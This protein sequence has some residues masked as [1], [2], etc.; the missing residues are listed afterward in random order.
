MYRAS[1]RNH[2]LCLA[3]AL[4][5]VSGFATASPRAGKSNGR[6]HA[7]AQSGQ[8]VGRTVARTIAASPRELTRDPTAAA[9]LRASTVKPGKPAIVTADEAMKLVRPGSWVL[10]PAEA[11]VPQPLVD[12]LGRR[13]IAL[14]TPKSGKPVNVIHSASLAQYNPDAI[15]SGALKIT[16]PFINSGARPY[17][18]Q[19]GV[20]NMM[21]IDLSDIPVYLREKQRPNVVLVNTSLPDKRGYVYTGLGLDIIA[22]WLADPRV[23]VIALAN[24]NVPATGGTRLHQSHIDRMVMDDKPLS[25]LKWEPPTLVDRAIGRNVAE[26]VKNGAT[27][28][29]GIGPL[30]TA[31]GGAL[32]KRGQKINEGGGKFKVR[33]RTEMIDDGLL[34]MLKAGIVSGSRDAVQ[35][36]FVAGTQPLYQAL[37]HDKRIKILP[38][39]VLNDPREAAKRNNLYAINSGVTLDLYGQSCAEMVPRTSAD[40]TMYPEA[41]SG[42]GGQMDFWRA[43]KWS[44]GGVGILTLRSTAK[45]GTLSSITLNMGDQLKA[46][47]SGV[48]VA[49]NVPG[50]KVTTGANDIQ[51]VATEWGIAK[52]RFNDDIS[53]AQALVRIAHPKFRA[54]L[55]QQGMKRFGGSP[56]SWAEAAK[57]SPREQRLSQFFAA[58]EAKAAAAAKAQAAK[59]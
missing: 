9:R 1:L 58:S 44:K 25:E 59:K 42:R 7:T 12:A 29:M 17:V 31:V 47:E 14:K 2:T 26:V 50:L 27:L 34:T 55:A 23:K 46:D 39:S 30:Q 16:A 15:T 20:L 49:G 45:N 13:A 37:G 40:G 10:L 33:I 4:V 52:L 57:V 6:P 56:E 32:A 53:R 21:A 43:V 24:P 36:G 3:L 28:Q 54:E 22:E 41:Y 38:T 48:R 11:G 51:W 35:V 5:L 19:P 8:Q 18:K